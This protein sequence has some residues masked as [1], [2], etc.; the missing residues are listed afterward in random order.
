MMTHIIMSF[1][2]REKSTPLPLRQILSDL[3]KQDLKTEA[4]PLQLLN[5]RWKDIVGEKLSLKTR[6]LKIY[7]TRLIIEAKGSVWVQELELMKGKILDSIRQQLPT[8]SIQHFKG[9]I[10]S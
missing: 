7:G 6:P 2:P 1:R 10:Q 9:L 3:F 5:D 4:D 8:L